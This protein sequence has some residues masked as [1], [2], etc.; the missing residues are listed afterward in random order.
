MWIQPS[1][2]W[3]LQ[4][5]ERLGRGLGHSFAVRRHELVPKLQHSGGREC[6]ELGTLLLLQAVVDNVLQSRIAQ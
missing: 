2:P 4:E 1:D 3:G 6:Q 5:S